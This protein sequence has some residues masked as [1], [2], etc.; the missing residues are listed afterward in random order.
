M[1]NLIYSAPRVFNHTCRYAPYRT[2]IDIRNQTTYFESTNPYRNVISGGSTYHVV[3]PTQVG[4]LDIISNIYY[5]SPEY[6]WLI[7]SA[8]DIIDPMTV[9]SGTVLLIPDL[10]SLYAQGGALVGR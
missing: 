7:A 4:R 6:Y 1:A 9:I 5:G 2:I 10:N 3:E 8:N